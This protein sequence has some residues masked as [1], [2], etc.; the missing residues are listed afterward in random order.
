MTRK[1]RPFV[2][3]LRAS[4][5]LSLF[6]AGAALAQPKPALVRDLDSPARGPVQVTMESNPDMC[7]PVAARCQFDFAELTVPAGKRLV[8]TQVNAEYGALSAAPTGF[9]VHLRASGGKAHLNF[10]AP[11]H[12]VYSGGV[13]IQPLTYFVE[14]GL[15]PIVT[16]YPDG[17]VG[18]PWGTVTLTGYWVDL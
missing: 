12:P 10:H 17:D 15:Y 13:V 2:G 9:A 3:W 16:I 18:K 14:A 1:P 6:L 4:A 7:V 11:G 8:I 5:A